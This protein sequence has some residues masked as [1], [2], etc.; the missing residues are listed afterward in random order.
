MKFVS[1]TSMRMDILVHWVQGD[2][3][4]LT[5]KYDVSYRC[6]WGVHAY[7]YIFSS[8]HWEGYLRI[9]NHEGILNF[10]TCPKYRYWNHHITYH[11]ILLM[12]CITLIF[13]NIHLIFNSGKAPTDHDI[14][15]F[16]YNLGFDL[17]VFCWAFL[18]HCTWRY[19]CCFLGGS[20]RIILIKWVT[21]SVF[22]KNVKDGCYFFL[23]CLI[24]F[25]NQA[26]WVLNL[27]CKFLFLIST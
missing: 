14:L 11:L 6:V 18:F 23:K 19:S 20:I 2:V 27:V 9:F 7:A 24:V 3:F 8:S 26:N 25:I 22:K 17:L 16:L 5:I 1:H 4:H 12:W 13:L 21:L 15:S 10:L